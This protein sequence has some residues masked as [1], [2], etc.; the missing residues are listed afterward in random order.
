LSRRKFTLLTASPTN[1][2]NC[3]YRAGKHISYRPAGDV[4]LDILKLVPE[5]PEGTIRNKYT[6]EVNKKSDGRIGT[7]TERPDLKV[8]PIASQ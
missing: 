4:V 3:W 7:L 2:I 6:K 5:A 8:P 1:G